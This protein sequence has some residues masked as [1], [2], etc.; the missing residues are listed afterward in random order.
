MVCDTRIS[1]AM[2][3]PVLEAQMNTRCFFAIIAISSALAACT[4]MAVESAPKKQ[5][6]TQRSDAAIK[7][8]ALF[9]DT[10]HNGE[11]EKIQNALEVLTAA[12]LNTP[13]D[14]ITAGHIG[15]LHFWRITERNRLTQIPASITDDIVV[16]RKYLQESVTL[17][18]SDARYQ[19]FLG[20]AMA[21]EGTI[22]HDEKL[23]R[24]GYYTLLDSAKAWP[25]FN[26]FTYGYVMSLQPADSPRFKE[27]LEW[28]WLTLDKCIEGKV[29]RQSVDYSA[30]KVIQASEG[31]KRVCGNSWI[32]PHNIEGFFLNMGDMLVKSGDWKTAQQIYAGARLSPGYTTWKFRPV[33]EDRIKDAQKN[34][35]LYNAPKD[36]GL[37]QEPQMMVNS[38]FACTACHQS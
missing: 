35:A 20:G 2:T 1:A 34:V 37:K 4:N 22:H 38:A 3:T 28:Q 21:I 16:A 5:T 25:E 10:L 8:D 13:N 19:G 23:V 17:N 6:A 36:L 24:R 32:A 18:P 31:V 7:A 29:D 27:G 33:L 26:L 11:Y 30:Y 9:W 14:S 12:Y 15:M